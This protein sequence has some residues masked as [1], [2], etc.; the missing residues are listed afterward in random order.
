MLFRFSFPGA[1][2]V[3]ICSISLL[4]AAPQDQVEKFEVDVVKTLRGQMIAQEMRKLSQVGFSGCILV[5]HEGKVIFV[6][7]H[8]F[9][10]VEKE[11]T[12]TPDCLFELGSLTKPFTAL[13]AMALVQNG[14]LELDAPISDYLPGVPADCRGI[15]VRHLMQQ[16]YWNA[17]RQL[18]KNRC[19]ARSRR[20]NDVARRTRVGSGNSTPLL[21]PGLLPA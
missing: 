11:E 8:G 12:L 18:R 15:N 1:L 17:K 5:A 20:R 13:A 7:S 2:F 4:Q 14:Q 19:R 16:H 10:D 3:V 21:E 9:G 6:H